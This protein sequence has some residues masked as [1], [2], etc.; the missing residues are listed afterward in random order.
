[1]CMHMF[2][3]WF[4]WSKWRPCLR[5]VLSKSSV[6]LWLF[7]GQND[8]LQRIFK[9]N[10]FLFMVGR[11][12][13]IMQFTT[14]WQTFCWWQRLKQRCGSGWDNTQRFLCCGFWHSDKVMGQV[15]QCWWRIFREIHF[16]SG[17]NVTCFIF[18][19]WLSL[20]CVYSEGEGE[21]EAS[22][23]DLV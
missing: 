14:G 10:C 22:I 5:S 4:Q 3:G 7:C 21:R 2:R 1:M 8:S 15:Y 16:F 23:V 17:S 18:I 19:Y 6:L 13:R 9:K 20:V 11:V 12:F